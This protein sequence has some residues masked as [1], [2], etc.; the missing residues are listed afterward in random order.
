LERKK[1]E[2]REIR[3]CLAEPEVPPSFSGF[4]LS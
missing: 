1:R 3:G 4:H 2:L